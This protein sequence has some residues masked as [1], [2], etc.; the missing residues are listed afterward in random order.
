LAKGG[1][2]S[3]R[4]RQ[5]P[6]RPHEHYLIANFTYAAGLDGARPR[7]LG[8]GD[9]RELGEG[10]ELTLEGRGVALE[11]TRGVAVSV[12]RPQPATKLVPFSIVCVCLMGPL[13][14]PGPALPL[15]RRRRPWVIIVAII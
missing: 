9:E 7:T 11:A 8:L 13:I 3:D 2:N 15:W 5:S 12:E 14:A 10:V 1:K 6:N 4:P